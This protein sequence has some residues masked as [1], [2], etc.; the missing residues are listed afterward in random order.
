MSGFSI[1]EW[2]S[3][4]PSAGPIDVASVID[5]EH[6]HDVKAIV[7]LID[8]PEVTSPSAVLALQIEPERSADASGVLGQT[9]VH[10]LDAGRRDLVR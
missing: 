6:R 2:E 1:A 7:D 5:G 8:D 10:E 4:A 9:A 3:S